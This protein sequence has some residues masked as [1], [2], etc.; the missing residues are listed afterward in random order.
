MSSVTERKVVRVTYSMDDIFKVPANID[1]ENKT[2]V[3]WWE[4]KYNRLSIKLVD[5][6]V[7]EI[8]SVWDSPFNADWK[9]PIETVIEDASEYCLDD[10]DEEEDK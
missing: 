6:K 4:V 1:L 8:E 3:E 9:H 2:Q 7:L 10:D 5:G